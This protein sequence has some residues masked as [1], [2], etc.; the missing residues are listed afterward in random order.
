MAAGMVAAHVMAAKMM[1]GGGSAVPVTGA[2]PAVSTHDRHCEEAGAT[3]GQ[4]EDVGIE[5]ERDG[6]KL[7][8]RARPRRPQGIKSPRL[9]RCVALQFVLRIGYFSGL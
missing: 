5:H 8:G 4:R 6:W 7:N 3:Q 9:T 2:R 1:V